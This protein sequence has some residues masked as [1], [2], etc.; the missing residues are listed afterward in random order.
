MVRKPCY[1][2]KALRSLEFP[3]GAIITPSIYRS[4]PGFFFPDLPNL[5]S[6]ARSFCFFSPSCVNVSESTRL[7]LTSNLDC[8][9]ARK[10]EHDKARFRSSCWGSHHKMHSTCIGHLDWRLGV[11]MSRYITESPRRDLA[12]RLGLRGP[13]W[14]TQLETSPSAHGH[15]DLSGFV[16][17][18]RDRVIMMSQQTCAPLFLST[19]CLPR[20]VG[21]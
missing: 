15:D 10:Y 11:N 6:F 4:C 7:L 18:F 9:C 8:I 19:D 21:N 5:P 13:L 2:R 14:C 1:R 12:S 20:L 16:R 17:L 3:K